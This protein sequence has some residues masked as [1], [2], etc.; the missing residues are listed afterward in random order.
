MVYTKHRKKRKQNIDERKMSGS[1][2]DVLEAR[3]KVIILYH[4]AKTNY[5]R[6]EIEKQQSDSKH[7]SNIT[8]RLINMKNDSPLPE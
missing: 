4:Q 1:R 7:L 3:S 5:F 8:K 6:I 2:L